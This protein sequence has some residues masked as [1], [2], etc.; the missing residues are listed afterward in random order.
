MRSILFLLVLLNF[1]L[2]L[3]QNRPAKFLGGKWGLRNASGQTVLSPRYDSI[4]P[5]SEGFAAVKLNNLWGFINQQG[6]ETV[7]PQFFSVL[8]F[9]E[10]LSAVFNGKSGYINYNGIFVIPMQYN[11]ALSFSNGYARVY[12]NG[13]W[14]NIDKSGRSIGDAPVLRNTAS[15]QNRS[16][17][18]FK[19][20]YSIER[21]GSGM[22]INPAIT[23]IRSNGLLEKIVASANGLFLLPYDIPVVF[24]KIGM[25]NAY[26][27]P[28]ERTIK[29]GLEFIEAMYASL[30]KQYSGQA[31]IDATTDAVVFI[32]FHEMGHALI[33]AFNIPLSGDEEEAADNFAIYL[34]TNNYGSGLD[35]IAL[36]GA[37]IF[38]NFSQKEKILNATI[39]A[40]EHLLSSQRAF[41][42]M[43]KVYG[44]DRNRYNYLIKQ[45][46]L[47]IDERR[48][49]GCVNEYRTMVN[50]WTRLLEPWVK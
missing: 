8:P 32:L 50:S 48:Q 16:G 22:V 34:F 40:D 30:S 36:N 25:V 41:R 12:S 6:I 23:A 43:C 18:E 20:L 10:G 47:P 13:K 37:Q 5:F 24:Q 1:N 49:L 46:I 21:S 33:D 45:G 19:L 15:E 28:Q 3:A 39:L 38:L 27:D 31:L 14:I 11:A 17:G 7:K 29:F 26:Y 4:A 2:A 42:I 9:S 35:V 44:K